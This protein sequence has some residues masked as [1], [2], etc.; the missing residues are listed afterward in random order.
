M[1]SFIINKDIRIML[2]GLG[3][4]R[5][6]GGRWV[7]LSEFSFSHPKGWA[8]PA[9]CAADVHMCR[10]T[11]QMWTRRGEP[12]TGFFNKPQRVGYPDSNRQ[13]TSVVRVIL[14]ILFLFLLSSLSTSAE[15][16]LPLTPINNPVI[17]ETFTG[18]TT[19]DPNISPDAINLPEEKSFSKTKA[20][21]LTMLVP[22]SGHFYLGQKGRGEV[23]MGAEAVAWA[24]FFAFRIYGSWRKDDYIRYAQNHAG[25]D[26]DG[27]ADDFYGRLSFY[28][29][30]DDYN[31]AGR[32]YNPGDPYYPNVS[33]YYWQWDS[34]ESRE[35]YRDVRNSSQ[36]SYRKATFMIGVAIFNRIVAGIDVFRLAGKLKKRSEYGDT[37]KFKLHVDADVFSQDPGLTL[38]LSRR[39]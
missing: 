3:A 1:K 36:S 18:I 29:S 32:L 25:I 30:R 33:T 39:F 10:V 19:G 38:T 28:D 6:R 24:G 9:L 14:L 21:L 16:D 11:R 12:G 5:R 20:V 35:Y 15:I 13:E 37:G 22:G 4:P 34:D 17:F 8:T 23:F 26:P 31:T 2:K 7:L 27:K